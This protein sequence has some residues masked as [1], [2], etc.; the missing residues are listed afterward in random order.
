MKLKRTM[1]M[2]MVVAG[3]LVVSGVVSGAGSVAVAQ[4]APAPM[5][6]SEQTQVALAAGTVILGAMSSG[7]DS[8]KAKAGDTFTART[9]QALKSGDG[10]TIMPRGTKL[11]G[12]V[13]QAEARNKGGTASTLGLQFD[14]AILK[15]GTE[16]PLNVVVQAIA[17]RSS[18][19]IDPGTRESDAEMP[20]TAQ[21]SPM[22]G[23]TPPPTTAPGGASGDAA[24]GGGGASGPSLDARSRGAVGMKGITLD[25][26]QA[27]NRGVT[28]VSSN[29]KSVK[30][31]DGVEV[32]LVAQ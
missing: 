7:L 17:A 5:A 31:D 4:D 13:T 22:A 18:G 9:T 8:K 28:V 32:V 12:H 2:A 14:K 24:G 25:A 6:R 26:A 30:L 23:R 16:I 15:D 29:G 21:T 27:E 19:P 1:E 10:R 3:G 20:K 11:Q